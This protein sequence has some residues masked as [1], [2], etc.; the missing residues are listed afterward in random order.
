LPPLRFSL[1]LLLLLL[2]L[3]L[4]LLV[5]LVLCSADHV[6]RPSCPLTSC[7]QT[8][9]VRPRHVLAGQVAP[10]VSLNIL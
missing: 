1:D 3:R 4:R 6:H 9:I 2:L 8:D 5:V 7:P 10:P